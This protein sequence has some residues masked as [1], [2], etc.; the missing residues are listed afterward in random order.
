[1]LRASPHTRAGD[2]SGRP[3]E[4]GGARIALVDALARCIGRAGRSVPMIDGRLEILNSGLINSLDLAEVIAEV[5]TASGVRFNPRRLNLMQGLT[6]DGLLA[7][8]TPPP[9]RPARGD[10]TELPLAAEPEVPRL[11]RP[12]TV[13]EVRPALQTDAERVCRFLASPYVPETAWRALFEHG[14][15]TARIEAPAGYLLLDHASDPDGRIVGFLAAK[16]AERQLESGPTR[17]CNIGMWCILPEYRAWSIQLLLAA[18]NEADVTYT[19]LTPSPGVARLLPRV[20]FRQLEEAKIVMPPLL[21]AKTLFTRGA[22]LEWEPF[23]V[24]RLLDERQRRVFDDHA[25][26]PCLQLFLGE[27]DCWAHLV[28][29]RRVKRGIAVS[30]LL[31]CDDVALLRRH[32]ERVK[33]VVLR[34]QGT[35]ALAADARLLGAPR[36]AGIVLSRPAFFRSQTLAPAEIDNLYSQIVLLPI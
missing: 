36:P 6:V 35:A 20:G 14:W 34:A 28:F 1:M 10:M 22:R 29:K 3:D 15:D 2:G 19:V 24:R 32:L 27:A 4:A 18:T 33:L 9:A 25:R 16:R 13:P 26:H 23:A 30:E 21:Q 5:E 7:A 31:G 8:F 12:V 11:R 17:V